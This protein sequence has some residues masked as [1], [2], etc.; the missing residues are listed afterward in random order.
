[1]SML[2][3]KNTC[4]HWNL[5][6]LSTLEIHSGKKKTTTKVVQCRSLYKSEINVEQKNPYTSQA[7]NNTP[8]RKR[9]QKQ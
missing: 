7:Y 2:K 1:M 5:T 6:I 4:R 3:K 8:C 9:K